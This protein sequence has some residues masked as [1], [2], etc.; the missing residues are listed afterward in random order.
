MDSIITKDW[1]TGTE[2]TKTK[3]HIMSKTDEVPILGSQIK[4]LIRSEGIMYGP[5][6]PRVLTT[7][8]LLWGMG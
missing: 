8:T 3:P 2:G 4:A 6:R 1:I 7:C 5:C